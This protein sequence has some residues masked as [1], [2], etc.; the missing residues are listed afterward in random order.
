[1]L[2]GRGERTCGDGM[3]CLEETLARYYKVTTATGT[4][5][6]HSVPAPGHLS[7]LVRKAD[8]SLRT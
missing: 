3:F 5:S 2:L 7:G 8:E 4:V 1:M 6:F